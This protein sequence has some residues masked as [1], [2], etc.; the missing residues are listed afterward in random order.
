MSDGTKGARSERRERIASRKHRGLR[1]D[2]RTAD[3]GSGRPVLRAVVIFCLLL[4]V[5]YACELTGA[6]DGS[7]RR[8]YLRTIAQS[9]SWI[10]GWC[11]Y[12]SR[13]EDLTIIA[14]QFS[15]TIVRGCDA[16][17]TIAAFG[18][19]VI[20]SPV[21]AWAK[22][23][24]LFAGATALLLLNLVRVVSLF[25][26]GIHAPA[27]FDVMHREVWQASFVVAAVIFWAI[28]VQ[29]ATGRRFAGP[30]S[31][32]PDSATESPGRAGG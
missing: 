6:S 27:A 17:D 13:V 7:W 5:F 4:A 25:L 31:S 23:P 32:G 20:A 8:A 1:G 12:A 22:L 21:T 3:R 11:G 16:L 29:W 28:W 14:P 15:V 10:L 19:A 18:A 26:V 30:E 2:G 24:G 9:S